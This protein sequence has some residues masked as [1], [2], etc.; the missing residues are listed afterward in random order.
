VESVEFF[1]E[2][3]TTHQTFPNPFTREKKE[4]KEGKTKHSRCS[5]TS[6]RKKNSFFSSIGLVDDTF[7]GEVP[8]DFCVW[9]GGGF[10]FVSLSSS[11]LFF[12]RHNF[13]RSFFFLAFFF[14]SSLFFA[15]S[16]THSSL[17]SVSWKK[18]DEKG[19]RKVEKKKTD[20]T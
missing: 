6:K 4:R 19:G 7:N 20:K 15:F 16:R 18:C 5:S 14:P 17:T 12:L 11:P 1:L 3:K 13:S 9:C 2:P 10:V 8:Q